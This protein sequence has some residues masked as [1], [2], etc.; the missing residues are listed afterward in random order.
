MRTSIAGATFLLVGASAIMVSAPEP[1]GSNINMNGSDTLFEVT[2][3]VLTLCPTKFADFAAQNLQYN[4]GG[5]GVG[6]AAM[7]NDAQRLAPM[8]RPLNAA[9]SPGENCGRQI[10]VDGTGLQATQTTTEGIVIALDGIS[11]LANNTNACGGNGIK[12]SGTFAVPTSGP[13]NPGCPGCD[14]SNNYTIANSLDTL[15]LM[16][17]GLHHDGTY[18]CN[19][20]VRRALIGTWA[21]LYDTACPA[22]NAACTAGATHAWRRSDLSGTTDLFQSL[23]AFAGRGLGNNP[24]AQGASL[25]K[26]QN[27]FCNSFDANNSNPLLPSHLPAFPI[28]NPPGVVCPQGF[29]CDG[30]QGHC[31]QPTV[32]TACGAGDPTANPPRP[33]LACAAPFVC[34]DP[35]NT[36]NTAVCFAPTCSAAS[37]TCPAG[38]VC[39]DATSATNVPC[40]QQCSASVLCPT[41]F[42]CDANGRCTTT[43]GGQ[44]DFAD[45]D[46]IRIPC[47]ANS[48]I[49][50]AVGAQGLGFVQVVFLPD[51]TGTNPAEEYQVGHPACTPGACAAQQPGNPLNVPGSFLCADGLKVAGGRCLRPFCRAGSAQ[52]PTATVDDYACIADRFTVCAGRPAGGDGR[53]YNKWTIRPVG[54][55]VAAVLPDSNSR[56]MNNSFFKARQADPTFACNAALDDTAQIG[57]LVQS[58]TCSVGFSG[59]EGA[60]GNA[61]AQ[62]VNSIFPT[63]QNIRNLLSNTP[64][65][66]QLSRRL[67]VNSLV[68]FNR[69]NGGEL[70]LQGCFSD[71]TLVN[72]AVNDHHFVTLPPGGLLCLDYDETGGTTAIN[73]NFAIGNCGATTN[74]D[75]CRTNPPGNQRYLASTPAADTRVFDNVP[76]GATRAQA[77]DVVERRC[78]SCHNATVLAGGFSLAAVDGGIAAQI[79]VASTECTAKVRVVG[80]VV[81]G[82]ATSYLMDKVLGTAQ[83]GTCFSPER[84]PRLQAQLSPGDLAVLKSWM[85]GGAP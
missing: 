17:G 9:G 71:N 67:F 72:T 83:D 26:K 36:T 2:R 42:G 24:F 49:C 64:P 46:P 61:I 16:Y 5:S 74:N 54:V 70:E 37:P 18:D 6:A 58:D 43:D 25:S 45:D 50:S 32:N 47:A 41:G 79:G 39:E 15:R 11:I 84:M 75:A 19:S 21:N 63:D 27:P 73:N 31:V 29:G 4:G 10:N 8:S 78:T 52:C 69:L 3:E 38:F 23:V 30:P 28:C 57:C 60:S 59:R 12:S 56:L 82:S 77:Q 51:V 66:Y 20:R 53:L 76:A 13:G 85:D 33:P 48:S 65:V 14:A 81:G 44:S 40:L 34:S 1:S 80:G 7:D 62:A 68:G 22:G 55:R 35:T